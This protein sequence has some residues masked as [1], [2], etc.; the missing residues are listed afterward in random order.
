MFEAFMLTLAGLVVM[1]LSPGPN[2]VAVATAALGGGRHTALA[3]TAG[4]A[5]GAM[6]W[7]V[8]MSAGLGA[9]LLQY[10]SFLV[11]MKLAGGSYLLW[12]GLKALWRACRSDQSFEQPVSSGLEKSLL[13]HYGTGL[14][15]VLTNP[16][17]ALG[18]AAIAAYLF[19]SGLGA[20]QVF[21]FAPLAALSAAVVYGGYALLFSNQRVGVLYRRF[22]RTMDL[23]LIH[24]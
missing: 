3:V 6:V 23:S 8:V 22:W 19:G 11:A 16:K 18:W 10:P 17:A 15:V 13:T 21:A 5:S 24:I 9:V 20:W 14:L 7:V 4:I 12:L 2:M 1:Q